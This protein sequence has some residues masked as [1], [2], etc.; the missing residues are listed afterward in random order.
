MRSLC[1]ERPSWL[2]K[3]RSIF[4]AVER[5]ADQIAER[6]VAGPEIVERDRD[7][8]FLQ[9]PQ[10][11]ERRGIVLQQARFRNFDFEPSRGQPRRLQDLFDTMR[12]VVGG[13]LQRR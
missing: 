13:D 1:F 9:H 7:A 11:I 10:L 2:T 12:N 4:D 8:E 6:R 5:K 3:R